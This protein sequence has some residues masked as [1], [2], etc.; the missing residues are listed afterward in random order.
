M[1]KVVK[2]APKDNVAIVLDDLV[3][4]QDIDVEGEN[5][6]VRDEIPYGHK[7]A[8]T[9]IAVGCCV[10]KYGEPVA[11]CTHEIKKGD[12]VHVHNVES[13]RGLGR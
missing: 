13:I 6:Q 5:I 9:D 7:I 1:R 11:R 2:F 4:D 10:Y 3:P 12:W 8:L